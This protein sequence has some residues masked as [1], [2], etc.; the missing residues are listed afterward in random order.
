MNAHNGAVFSEAVRA[1]TEWVKR[2]VNVLKNANLPTDAEIFSQA[3]NAEPSQ[4]QI[5]GVRGI[6]WKRRDLAKVAMYRQTLDQIIAN[7][8]L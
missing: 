3:G 4:G 6:S 2:A 7:R 5:A 8:R 1:H